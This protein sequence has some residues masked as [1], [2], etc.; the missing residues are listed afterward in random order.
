MVIAKQKVG[1]FA[2]GGSKQQGRITAWH[3]GSAGEGE[4]ATV[5]APALGGH[6]LPARGL[7]QVLSWLSQ[8]SVCSK[9]EPVA[10]AAAFQRAEFIRV[11]GG[12][13]AWLAPVAWPL[14][15]KDAQSSS[16]C[17][18]FLLTLYPG[19]E[20]LQE[21]AFPSGISTGD[22]LHSL[23]RNLDLQF[24]RWCWKLPCVDPC[25]WDRQGSTCHRDVPN[26]AAFMSACSKGCA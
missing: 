19:R 11:L 24:R 12:V 1:S 21:L 9:Q 20:A 13:A 8:A 26:W 3:S 25:P 5:T 2:F 4:Q 22:I 7:S 18:I 14:S 16:V 23:V 10:R 17:S 15:C 6:S